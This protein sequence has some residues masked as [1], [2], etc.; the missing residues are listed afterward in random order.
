[1]HRP[2]ISRDMDAGGYEDI[3]T[4]SGVGKQRRGKA[5]NK[6]VTKGISSGSTKEGKENR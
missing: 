5:S 6:R 4:D 1:M 3:A 2:K